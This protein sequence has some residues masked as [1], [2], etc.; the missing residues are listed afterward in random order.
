MG[1]TLVFKSIRNTDIGYGVVCIICGLII[2]LIIVQVV[3][4]FPRGKYTN[5]EKAFMSFAWVPKATVQ[6]ALS[7]VILTDAKADNV[8]DM[9]EY[10]NII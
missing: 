9:I 6:A 4:Y 5:Q 7:A 2:R 1:A 3:A 8:P 10:G